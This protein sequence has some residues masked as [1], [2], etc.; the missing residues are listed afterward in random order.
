M[1]DD[2]DNPGTQTDEAAA[3]PTVCRRYTLAE[4]IAQCNPDAPMTPEERE[5]VDAPAVGAS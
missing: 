2:Q 3:E 4:L 5:W 1:M